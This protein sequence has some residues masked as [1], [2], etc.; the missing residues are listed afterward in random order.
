MG[1]PSI[2]CMFCKGGG[3]VDD[4]Y[5]TMVT[6][7]FFHMECLEIELNKGKPSELVMRIGEE[8]QEYLDD[9]GR[10]R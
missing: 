4:M 6:D 5:F 10:N 8:Y 9:Y 3:N 1:E 7:T 2:K